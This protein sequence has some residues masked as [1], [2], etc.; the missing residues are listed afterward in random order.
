MLLSDNVRMHRALRGAGVEAELHVWEAAGHGGF[1]GM[2]PEDAE[3]FGGDATLRRGALGPG[4]A[5]P[6]DTLSS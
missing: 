5:G 2:A 6:G 1:L 4:P 3:R